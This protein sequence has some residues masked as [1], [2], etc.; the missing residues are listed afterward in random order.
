MMSLQP[1]LKEKIKKALAEKPGAVLEHIAKDLGVTT[2]YV[3][4]CLPDYEAV[5]LSSDYFEEVM[6]SLSGL[7]RITFVVHTD[8]IILE[9]KGEVPNGSYGRGY[10]NI[11][12]DSP[13]GGHIKA[14]NCAAIFFISRKLM[15]RESHSIQFYNRAGQCI[16]KVYL[17]RD[18]NHDLIPEQVEK[19]Y[20][21]RQK[22][23][24]KSKLRTF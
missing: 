3:A 10:F 21:L 15:G 9:C 4:A 14:E 7:G 20:A 18:E 1:N 23:K 5:V 17:G 22:Y 24:Q 8:D 11:H 12:G 6:K 16:Y 13:I 19:Y 2:A